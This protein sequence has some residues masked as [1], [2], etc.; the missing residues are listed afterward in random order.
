M[1]A[2]FVA[3]EGSFYTPHDGFFAGGSSRLR[4]R[5]QVT[6]ATRDLALLEQLGACLATGR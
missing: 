1:L 2:G 5:F 3:G 4:F 6:V